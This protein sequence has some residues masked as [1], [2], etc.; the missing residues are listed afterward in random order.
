MDLEYSENF[1]CHQEY[2]T[3]TKF[4]VN[5]K[6]WLEGVFLSLTGAFGMLGNL[7][8]LRVLKRQVCNLHPATAPLG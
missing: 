2:K 5:V 4:V 3:H 1:T 7:I 8:T 6:F